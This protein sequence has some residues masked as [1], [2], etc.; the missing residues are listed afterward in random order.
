MY[1]TDQCLV[2]LKNYPVDD[3]TWIPTSDVN[4][5]FT[6]Y[7]YIVSY[8][9][10]KLCHACTYIGTY[11]GEPERAPHWSINTLV[12][13]TTNNDCSLLTHLYG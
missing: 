9:H 5:A 3:A 13:Y 2:M 7:A 6:E 10:Y 8:W 1:R 11:W 12:T 4:N